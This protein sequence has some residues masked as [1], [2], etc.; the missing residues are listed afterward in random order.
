MSRP[1]N[2]IRLGLLCWIGSLALVLAKGPTPPPPRHHGYHKMM[3]LIMNNAMDGIMRAQEE[4]S[5]DDKQNIWELSGLDEGDIMT[6]SEE[7]SRNAVREAESK[8]PGGVVPYHISD[9][10]DDEEQ[11]VI[12]GAMEEF[13][14]NSCI[15]FRPY[16]EGDSSWVA[17]KNDSPGCWSYVGRRG[18]GQVVNLGNRCVQHGVAAHE[19][20][21]ALGFHHQ[22]STHNRD[23]YVKIHWKNIRRGTERN[24]KRYPSSRVQDFNVP[25]DYESVMHYSSHAFSK[26]GKP[27]ITP[28]E[29]GAFI[30]QRSRMSDKDLQKLKLMYGCESSTGGGITTENPDYDDHYRNDNFWSFHFSVQV[31]VILIWISVQVSVILIWISVQVAV[32]LVY[33]S[34]QVSVILIWISVQVSIILVRISVQVSVIL[35]LISVQVSVILIWISV[36]V[37]VILI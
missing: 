5:P 27:T 10:F 3:S 36:Q 12:K 7:T 11:Q 22:Q 29:E 35:I 6:D 37:S 21:H 17:I 19:L 31:S 28:K 23:K 1:G 14:E 24:F 9:E 15:Q 18:G 25:Y 26:N 33:I 20:L 16:K 32:I 4:W 2:T 13:H 8:W 30:G 34:F